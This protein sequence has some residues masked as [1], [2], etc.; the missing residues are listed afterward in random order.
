[1]HDT[2]DV[3]RPLAQAITDLRIHHLTDD[4]VAHAAGVLLDTLGAALVG[5]TRP[6][7]VAARKVVAAYGG[8]PTSTVIA[9]PCTS[10]PFAAFLNGL[11]GSSSP[12]MD[13]IWKESLGHPGVG[14]IPATLAVA[15]A[16]DASGAQIVEAVVAGYEVAMRIGAALGKEGLDNGW[17]PRGGVNV[18]GAA[19]AAGKLLDLDVDRMVAALSLAGNTAAGLTGAVHFHDAWYAL[20]A[21][22][23][24]NGVVAA[25]LAAAGYTSGPR[26]LESPYGGYLTTIVSSPR[27]DWLSTPGDPWLIM[28]VGQKLHASSAA[29]HAAVDA[30]LSVVRD[31]GLQ[32]EDVAHVTIFGFAAMAG[33]LGRPHPQTAVHAGM[34]IPY[35]VATVI[36][37]RGAGLE[38]V[39]EATFD[40]PVV[41]SL[42]DR[43]EVVLDERLDAMC[44]D[45]LGARV[46]ITTHDGRVLDAE[47]LH[48]KGDPRQPLTAN[49]RGAK[50]RHL[51][52]RVLS[53]DAVVEVEAL[54]AALPTWTSPAPLMSLLG[55]SRR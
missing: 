23:S 39:A 1:M 26:I 8:A 11:A 22:A 28:Q 45:T 49:E 30:A 13:D 24:L 12:Q 17:H 4:V 14:V 33:R 40:D 6:H 18:F 5:S 3:T 37:R 21:N 32:P 38:E 16:V 25:D 7:V 53:P 31:N 50:F 44:P 34:S 36:A 29:T 42:Q 54:V 9:G 27:W 48:A 35:L 55:D 46:V 15:E 52:G 43:I 10:A 20:S 47:V 19:A 51:A 41:Q 2:P